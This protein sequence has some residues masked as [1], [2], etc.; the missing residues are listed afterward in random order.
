MMN[1]VQE[2][3]H[4]TADV[5]NKG[6]KLERYEEKEELEVSE[7]SISDSVSDSEESEEE[8]EKGQEIVQENA[9][10]EIV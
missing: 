9:A 4:Q 8:E 5:G 2:A 1:G 7:D 3:V 6:L 10:D